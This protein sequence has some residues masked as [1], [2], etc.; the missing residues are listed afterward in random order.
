MCAVCVGELKY[1]N[2]KITL[3]LMLMFIMVMSSFSSQRMAC[4]MYRST[5]PYELSP[6]TT[7]A[8]E[9]LRGAC[10]IQMHMSSG[11]GGRRMLARARFSSAREAQACLTSFCDSVQ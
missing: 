7:R 2:M 9:S 10:K 3:T 1:E 4:G 5:F 8:T 6:D 11:F